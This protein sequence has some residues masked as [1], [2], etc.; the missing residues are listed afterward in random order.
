MSPT[1]D[2]KYQGMLSIRTIQ[3]ITQKS[4]I[5]NYKKRKAGGIREHRKATRLCWCDENKN[6]SLE[7]CEKL[8]ITDSKVFTVDGGYNPQNQRYYCWNSEDVPVHY[9]D[10]SKKGVHVYGGMSAR[11]LTKLI[12]MK[13]HITAKDM[14]KRY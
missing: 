4:G 1:K 5:K 8:L 7:Y 12:F 13:E 14:S 3:K 2:R 9:F 11:G 6:W 10:K